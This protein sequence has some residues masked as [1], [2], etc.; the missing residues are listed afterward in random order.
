MKLK[1]YKYRLPF[2]QPLETSKKTFR[3]RRGIILICKSNNE[4]FYGEAAPLPGYSTE[5]FSE[6]QQSL[7]KLKEKLP[8]LLQ[9][10]APIK[11]LQSLYEKDNI[12]ASLQFC[13]D[14]LG[15]Q[16]KAQHS[17][18][19]FQKELFE[20]ASEQIP[21]N[22]LGS[23]Q[24]KQYLSQ[25]KNFVSEGF[26]T[27][28]YKVGIDFEL[29]LTR[30]KKVRSHFPDLAIRI[31]ANQCWSVEEALKNGQKLSPLNIEYCEEPLSDPAPEN[32]ELLSQHLDIP[33]ALDESQY[34]VS[35]WPNLLPYTRYLILKPMLLGSFTKIF[36]TKR[37]ADTHENKVVFTTSLESGIGRTITAILASEEESQHIAHGLTTGQL[38]ANDFHDDFAYISDGSYHISSQQLNIDP[39]KISEITRNLFPAR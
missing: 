24:P 11:S 32:F 29:E 20:Q 16:I 12:P 4:N 18:Q 33:I 34:Q 26:E 14:S 21:I 6:V 28:K 1:Y 17:N 38:L 31:D 3:Y 15:Y 37:L 9:N 27:I 13:L 35:Y 22:A 2:V 8:S 36:E 23:L 19:T 10:D 7:E 39:N 25:A 5:T 30:L